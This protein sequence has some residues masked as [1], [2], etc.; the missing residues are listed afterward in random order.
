MLF[1]ADFYEVVYEVGELSWLVFA[2]DDVLL[3]HD[4][5]TDEVEFEEFACEVGAADLHL[6]VLFTANATR[7]LTVPLSLRPAL[8]KKPSFGM[9]TL[10]STS[11]SVP[12]A[13]A[14]SR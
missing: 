6:L 7:S 1:G 2:D 12:I 4:G 10:I 3:F 9:E 5:M 8:G 11:R 14:I 13:S